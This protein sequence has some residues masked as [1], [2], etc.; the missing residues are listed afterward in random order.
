MSENRTNIWQVIRDFGLCSNLTAGRQ[1]TTA[2]EKKGQKLGSGKVESRSSSDESF[3][4]SPSR[5]W[6]S[7]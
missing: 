4:K 6:S 1:M 7:T 3:S 5:S 2:V